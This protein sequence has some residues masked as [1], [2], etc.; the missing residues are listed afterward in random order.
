HL[1]HRLAQPT[2]LSLLSTAHDW[3]Q[4]T[5]NDPEVRDT[6]RN[7]WRDGRIELVGGEF[8]ETATPLLSAQSGI[9]QLQQGLATFRRLFDRSPTTWG[10]KR[11]GVDPALPMLVNRSGMSAAL[12]FVIDDGIYPDQ[13]HS[14]LR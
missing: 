4:I 12:H 8:R 13:E 1:H 14:K 11:F 6:I 7:L 10:R 3:E 2:P 5:D 9:W